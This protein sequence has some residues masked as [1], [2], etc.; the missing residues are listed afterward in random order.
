MERGVK[1]HR[2]AGS[3]EGGR[4]VCSTEKVYHYLLDP[5]ATERD[6][7]IVVDSLLKE[8]LVP[9]S[10][11]DPAGRVP[12]V[13][14]RLRLLEFIYDQIARP[15]LG[16]PY[17]NSGVF[18]SPVDFRLMAGH[19]LPLIQGR[20]MASLPRFAVPVAELDPDQAIL[21]WVEG[22]EAGERAVRRLG[23]AALAEA[24]EKWP[25]SRVRE[26]FG[27][28]LTKMF[29]Y[30]PQVMTYQGRVPLR[31]EWLER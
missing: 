17:A 12:E 6:V 23:P 11:Q 25:A 19:D 16:R 20:P 1:R 30:V 27:R 2:P 8:G 22:G 10:D 15:V 28:D 24:A 31:P 18:L 9:L 3:R 14:E 4:P 29:F 13:A 7:E 21:T 5:P 26:W